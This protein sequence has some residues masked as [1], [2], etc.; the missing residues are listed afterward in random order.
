MDI[1][2]ILEQEKITAKTMAGFEEILAK[3]LEA[4]GATDIEVRTRAVYFKGDLKTIYRANLELRTA[5]RILVPVIKFHAFNQKQLYKK[6]KAFP[7][8][9][10]FGLDQTFAISAFSNSEI[11]RHSK[12]ASL[13]VKDAIV[14]GFRDKFDERP[15]VDLKTPDVRIHLHIDRQNVILSV[16]SS[17]DSLHKRGYK[18]DGLIA[19][20]NEVL[21]SGMLILAGWEGQSDF[22]DPM[23]GSG[24]L[25]TEAAFIATNT[26][27]LANR[28]SFG[29]MNWPDYD[30]NLWNQ[31]RKDAFSRTKNFDYGIYASDVDESHVR[32]AKEN[33]EKAGIKVKAEFDAKDFFGSE[34]PSDE[35]L[36]VMN[37]PYGERIEP[38]EIN[39]FYSSIGDQFKQNC[40]GWD[41]W[42]IS[43]NMQALKNVGLR[44]SRKIHLFNGA[45]ECKF[46]KY[47][48]Y[49][50]SKRTKFQNVSSEAKPQD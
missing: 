41:A 6:T 33:F 40:A 39:S 5:I 15:S 11:F 34:T 49:K 45:L 36:I 46:Q 12:Y 22:W 20:L 21:A 37:P 29:F 30:A 24:T 19:P 9:E 47:S 48:I 8:E 50:G 10:L 44:P 7:W 3:E 35:G 16:D 1:S 32:V 42:M 31:V 26:P 18:S 28:H 27:A 25:A 43:S 17:G 38:E 14:D 23:C 4:I 2:A 13:V